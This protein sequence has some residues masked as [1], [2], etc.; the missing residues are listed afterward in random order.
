MKKRLLAMVCAVLMIVTAMAGTMMTAA[1]EE[2]VLTVYSPK[3]GWHEYEQYA[4][5]LSWL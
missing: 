3:D 4:W 2:R 1:A 5:H